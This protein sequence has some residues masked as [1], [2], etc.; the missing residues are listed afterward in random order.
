MEMLE[1]MLYVVDTARLP[2]K[3][4]QEKGRAPGY[5]FEEQ[6]GMLKKYCES[7]FLIHWKE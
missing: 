2:Q 7:I 1:L 4:T 6:H 5:R 3:F